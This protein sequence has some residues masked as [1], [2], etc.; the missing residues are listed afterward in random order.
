[1]ANRP[2]LVIFMPDQ[3]RADCVGAFGN[4]V[5]QT[6][7]IDALA[8]R[9]TVFRNAFS[10]S[11]VCSQSRVSLLT[12]WYLHVAGH[13]TLTNLLKPWEPNLFGYLKGA[14]YHVAMAGMRGD[15]FAPGGTKANTDFYGF[16]VRPTHKGDHGAFPP[17]HRFTPAFYDGRRQ[18]EGPVLD[19]DEAAT[20]TAEDL[21][22][23]GM[24]EPWALYIPLVF[25]HCPFAVEEPWFSL[26][27]RSA[28]PDPLPPVLDD[29]PAF[30]Q[31]IRDSYGLE[32]LDGDDWA[33]II[34]TY[35]GMISRVDDQLGRVVHAV[36]RA[37]ATDRTAVAFFTDHGEYL[38]D[39]GLIEKWPT[40]LNDCL[41]RNPLILSVPGHP[42]GGRSDELVEMVDVMPTLLELADTETRHTHFGRSLVPLLK[43]PSQSHRSAAYSE[44]GAIRG[45]TNGLETR[46]PPPYH[47]KT[48]LQVD[49]PDLAGKATAMRTERWTFVHRLYE[50]DELYDRA[51]DPGELT[52]LAGKPE[53]ADV[54]RDLRDQMLDWLMET[55]DV[56]PWD[57]DPRFSKD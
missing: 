19:F 10:Q 38:G 22:A 48:G 35:Y 4:P 52:N 26:H 32:R 13:R 3:L 27:D 25:P 15:T 56:V 5:V 12:G 55:A 40:G 24:P 18:S 9:G 45:E 28:V 14:G 54:E 17:D 23:Q 37:G 50:N 31:A 51:A 36:D 2:N 44:G 6:P 49:Q 21:L 57:A 39:Y 20:R 11:S 34:A 1:M 33:E 46:T 42:E 53:V 30:M 8:A 43:D 47:L 29:K 16:T 41:V 7:N